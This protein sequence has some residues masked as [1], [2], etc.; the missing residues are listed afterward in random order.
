AGPLPPRRRRGPGAVSHLLLADPGAVGA[1]PGEGDGL[2]RLHRVAL[3]RPDALAGGPLGRPHGFLRHGA[4]GLRSPA[5]P[6]TRCAGAALGPTRRSP[7]AAPNATS[8]AGAGRFCRS[9]RG[10][11][12]L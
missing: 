7:R 11:L 4:R 2:A 1:A 6:G 8:R 5:T 3:E 10:G 12:I 9:G